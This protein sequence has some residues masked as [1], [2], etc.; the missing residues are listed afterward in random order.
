MIKFILPAIFLV[1]CATTPEPNPSPA[2]GVDELTKVGEKID[3]SE[4]LAA[5]AITVAVEQADKPGVVKAEGKVALAYLVP[6][7]EP[8]IALARQR[9][10]TASP[11]AYSKQLVEAKQLQDKI[12]SMWNKA[13]ADAI[14][15]KTDIQALKDR[16][17]ELL[18]EVD[19]VKQ[20]AFQSIW[21]L[22]GAALVIGGG[23]ACAFA[24]VR[25]GI[26]IIATGLLA[27]AVPFIID[28]EY[29]SIVI[30]TTLSASAALAIWWMYDKVRDSVNSNGDSSSKS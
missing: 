15:S 20:E 23:L 26:P 2:P 25:I 28:S 24:S 6:A 13:E 29:F 10:S 3:R 27:G 17:V 16:N 12:E 9:A 18:K 14:K 30:G 21:S 1:A 19:R 5:A 4:Q 8:D 7:T 11:E 22:T